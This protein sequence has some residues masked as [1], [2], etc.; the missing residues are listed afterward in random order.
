MY[1]I[2]IS[3]S[4]ILFLSFYFQFILFT[5]V[6]YC[7]VRDLKKLN[8]PSLLLQ[9]FSGWHNRNMW[10]LPSWTNLIPNTLTRPLFSTRN[11]NLQHRER[12][13]LSAI[14]NDTQNYIVFSKIWRIY[15][16]ARHFNA[17]NVFVKLSLKLSLCYVIKTIDGVYVLPSVCDHLSKA[18]FIDSRK[19][20]VPVVS[21]NSRIQRY[22]TR[23]KIRASNSDFRL[24]TEK[25]Q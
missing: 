7:N 22:W 3:I 15:F 21:I 12:D 4:F 20:N 14:E 10:H 23:V 5:Y 19:I 13:P 11:L 24:Q 25:H 8:I 2:E 18:L 9:H 1:K 16:S 17:F 6:I